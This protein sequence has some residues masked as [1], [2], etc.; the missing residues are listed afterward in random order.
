MVGAAIGDCV[1]VA[2]LLNFF[3]LAEAEGYKT[4]FLGAAVPVE[5]L[6]GAAV[7]ADAEAI[8]VSYRL[9]P[10]AAQSLFGVLRREL[11]TNGLCDRLLLFGGTPP[12]A[13]EATASEIF[14]KVFSGREDV[15]EVIA[16][17]RGG[18][19]AAA[20]V[21]YARNLVDRIEQKSPYPLIRHHFGLPSVADT[22]AGIEAIASEEVVDVI[23]I[24]PD[25]NAQEHFFHPEEMDPLQDGA[26]GVPLRSREDFCGLYQ[27]SQ[28]GNYPLLRCYSGTTDLVAMAQLLQETINNA[29]AAVPLFWYNQMD[30][31]SQRTLLEAIQENQQVM[32]WHGE[33][34]IP[35]EVNEAHHWSLRDAHD[36]I[37][38]VASFLAAYNAKKAGVKDYVAQLMFN[39]PPMTVP[40]M[41]LAKMMAKL[42]LV[43]ELACKDFTV[44]RQ[45]RAG[46]SSFPADL[47]VAKGHLASS[48]QT[49][50][51]LS[52][53][54]VHVVGYCEAVHIARAEDV[55][56]SCRIARGVLRNVLDGLPRVDHD[57]RLRTRRLQLVD[58]ARYLL[59]RIWAL[60]ATRVEDPWSCAQI[61]EE[62][63]RA[64]L[65]DAPH[66]KNSAIAQGRL[67]TRVIDGACQAVGTDGMPISER[68]RVASLSFD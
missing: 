1:H 55:I 41:D 67:Q 59:D 52:P 25:Q 32:T 18:A 8:A 50:M 10:G 66:L 46:L 40:V 12:V 14:T 33:C 11:E 63:V 64:G 29:W 36:V 5:K 58:E 39:T 61:L 44:Y 54:L 51:V 2:G 45:V 31:R 48:L 28:R 22:I 4:V 20:Q 49:A 43:Q 9:D 57:E 21:H 24:G 35:V 7:E 38:V 13:E 42:D 23:S 15:D 68:E 26:G 56:A 16:Y 27:A 60:G 47:D 30:G 37:A 65:M 53:H 62:T 6:V 3:K 17:L 19:S 34:G